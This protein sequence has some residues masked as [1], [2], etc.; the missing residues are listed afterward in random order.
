MNFAASPFFFRMNNEG[1]YIRYDGDKK[2]YFID[3]DYKLYMDKITLLYGDT[4]S[5]KSTILSE[6]LYLLKNKVSM[7]FVF[8]PTNFSNRA[9]DGIIPDEFIYD[10]VD[11][12]QLRNIWE[13]QEKRA[14]LYNVANDLSLLKVLFDKVSAEHEQRIA[15]LIV[16]NANRTLDEIKHNTR[17]DR[18][19]K[20]SEKIDIEKRK[21]NF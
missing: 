7:A 15:N 16:T 4:G 1:D 18:G 11:I 21:V 19:T 10:D 9:F 8:S 12:G 14:K 6:M 2:I 20:I 17:L 3:K 13:R 5:G